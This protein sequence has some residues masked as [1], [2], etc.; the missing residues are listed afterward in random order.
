MVAGGVAQAAR[1]TKNA[2]SDREATGGGGD[3]YKKEIDLSGPTGTR[4]RMLCRLACGGGETVN[5]ICDSGFADG[6]DDVVGRQLQ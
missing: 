1:D 5:F 4:G 2:A 6:S 3:G